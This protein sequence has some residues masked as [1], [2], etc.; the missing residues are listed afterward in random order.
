M[1]EASCGRPRI[2]PGQYFFFRHLDVEG[3]HV[4]CADLLGLAESAC[5]SKSN[6]N[7]ESSSKMCPV[8]E[9]QRNPLGVG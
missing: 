8:Y 7:P 5:T 6:W 9:L 3:S 4:K 2:V 1:G